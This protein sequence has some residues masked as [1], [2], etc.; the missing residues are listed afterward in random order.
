VDSQVHSLR[1]DLESLSTHDESLALPL[2]FPRLERLSFDRA[3]ASE[4]SSL[5]LQLAAQQPLLLAHLHELDLSTC[6]VSW[7][8]IVAAQRVAPLRRGGGA[9]A[10]TGQ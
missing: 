1:A 2:C 3:G 5:L 8:S 7:L 6:K 4:S 10:V 9:R